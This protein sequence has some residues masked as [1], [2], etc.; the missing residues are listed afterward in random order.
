MCDKL[1]DYTPEWLGL[2]KDVD[3]QP[4]PHEVHD[5]GDE[6]DDAENVGNQ[7]MLQGTQ[8][9]SSWTWSTFSRLV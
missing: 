7:G 3:D 2:E 4:V 6:K 8:L 5:P 1:T 9:A